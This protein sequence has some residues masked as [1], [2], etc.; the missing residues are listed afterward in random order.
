MR[1]EY[2]G[3]VRGEE[4]GRGRGCIYDAYLSQRSVE[5]LVE[6]IR[7]ELHEPVQ[8]VNSFTEVFDKVIFIIVH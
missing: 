4:R 7:N 1:K 8:K 2:R 5:A 3:K 6:F